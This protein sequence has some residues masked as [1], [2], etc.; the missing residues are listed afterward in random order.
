VIDR[1]QPQ[2]CSNERGFAAAVR[3]E[4]CDYLAGFNSQIHVLEH[5]FAVELYA[6]TLDFD[7]GLR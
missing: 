3:P 4:K 2:H 7:D 5:M 6:E 1:L